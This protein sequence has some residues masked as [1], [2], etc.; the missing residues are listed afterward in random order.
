ML[1]IIFK[2][3]LQKKNMLK[4]VSNNASSVARIM[5][6]KVMGNVLWGEVFPPCWEWLYTSREKFDVFFSKNEVIG[7]FLVHF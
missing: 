2:L 3:F 5:L 6:G 1:K 7:A 4:E